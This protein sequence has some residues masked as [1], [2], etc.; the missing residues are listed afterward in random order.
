MTTEGFSSFHD[1]LNSKF[2][3]LDAAGTPYSVR[4]HLRS[5]IKIELSLAD[6]SR[7]F[8]SGETQDP[9]RHYAVVRLDDVVLA[10]IIE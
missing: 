6:Y 8:I 5:G 4:L 1:K 2:E 10:E 9:D 7:E 3:S